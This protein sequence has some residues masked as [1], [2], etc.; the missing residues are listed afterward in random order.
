MKPLIGIVGKYQTRN[1]DDFWHRHGEV[2]EIRFLLTRYGAV[3][4]MLLPT[5]H[6]L[7]FN[8]NDL[9]DSTVLNEEELEDLYRQLDLVDGIVL[10]GGDYS[11]QYEVEL[12]KKAIEAD[13]PV[14]GICA[15]FNN[16]LRA[17]GTNTYEDKSNSHSHYDLN[18]RHPIRVVKQTKLYEIIGKEEYSVNSMHQMLAKAE[19]LQGYAKISS[20]SPDGLVES[21]E[22]EDRK[23]VMGLKWH[24]E[25]M[26]D[27]PE[28][29]SIFKAFVKACK[30]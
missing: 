17:L 19:M 25:Q 1:K 27:D 11:C 8:T 2:D 29:G 23:F 13:K 15:G 6:S 10:Q 22:L 3:S 9:G 24:P 7:E 26:R 18:Y 4:I 16:I 14:L 12:A 28:T 30:G 20:Y 5:E 21:I